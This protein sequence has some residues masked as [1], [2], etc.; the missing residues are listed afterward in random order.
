[1]TNQTAVGMRRYIQL[2]RTRPHKDQ[3]ALT[4]RQGECDVTN[5]TPVDVGRLWTWTVHG[6]KGRPFMRDYVP[7]PPAS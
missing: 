4:I 6:T 7:S 2:E 3:L 1:M 5:D